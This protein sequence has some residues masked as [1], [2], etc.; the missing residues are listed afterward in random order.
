MFTHCLKSFFILLCSIQLYT[1]VVAQPDIELLNTV[2]QQH[3]RLNCFSG[4]VLV[5]RGDQVLYERAF[6]L[7]DRQRNIANRPDTRFNLCSMG[8]TM[9]A[10]LIMQ[11]IE[12]GTL[13]LDI[14]I[15]SYLPQYPLP[16]ADRITIHHLLTHSSGLSNYM[17]H[18]DYEAN[19]LR[20]NNLDSVMKVIVQM[21]LAFDPPGKQFEYSNSGFIV[22]GKILETVTGKNYWEVLQSEILEPLAMEHTWSRFPVGIQAPRE[23]VPYYVLS[24]TKYA[25]ARQEESP[26]FSDG[27]IYAS[28]HDIFQFA[29]ALLQNQLLLPATRN[30]MWEPRLAYPNEHYHYG[31]EMR[32][33]SDGI[34][35][36][37]HGGGGRGF[38]THLAILPSDSTIVVVMANYRFP[39]WEITDDLVQCLRSGK[40]PVVDQQ[41]EFALMAALEK[42]NPASILAAYRQS[43]STQRPP[44]TSPNLF[45]RTADMLH[46]MQEEELAMTLYQLNTEL[47]PDKTFSWLGLAEHYRIHKQQELAIKYFQQVL[48]MDPRNS[49]AQN[50]LM[51]L[52]Q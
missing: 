44:V 2:M 40:A 46:E 39:V 26:A 32:P 13:A 51:E 52:N 43:P 35:I 30:L 47:F 14:P 1:S 6:G 42:G 16:N 22:L 50:R 7:A 34:P 4:V 10:T 11:Q 27:G 36:Y 41:A 24:Q 33:T 45:I 37:Q 48:T 9:T 38:T 5:A 15:R 3:I 8:K 23:A 20:F 49:F 31:W 29:W 28:A 17:M 12:K 25:D 21:P 18:P 19:K